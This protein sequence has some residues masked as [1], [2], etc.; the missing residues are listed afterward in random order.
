MTTSNITWIPAI[1]DNDFMPLTFQWFKIFI[2]YFLLRNHLANLYKAKSKQ[3]N[4]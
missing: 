3:T 2:K 4:V 1:Q